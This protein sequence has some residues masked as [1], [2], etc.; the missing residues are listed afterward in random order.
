MTLSEQH[1]LLNSQHPGARLLLLLQSGVKER[2]PR[3]QQG[4]EVREDAVMR[5]SSGTN[6]ACRAVEA[7]RVRMTIGVWG[8]AGGAVVADRVILQVHLASQAR[9]GFG[10]SSRIPFVP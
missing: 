6:R 4:W 8:E 1:H 3:G 5:R 2:E 9:A 10:T 7:G